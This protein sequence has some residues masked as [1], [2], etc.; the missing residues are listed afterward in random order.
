MLVFRLTEKTDSFRGAKHL[1]GV[2]V[3]SFL[4]VMSRSRTLQNAHVGIDRSSAYYAQRSR[5][6]HDVLERVNSDTI[7]ALYP[8]CFGTVANVATA[9]FLQQ[10]PWPSVGGQ[11]ANVASARGQ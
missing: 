2:A 1:A 4:R 10:T 5:T 11:N 8:G 9:V 3:S 7:R 6:R